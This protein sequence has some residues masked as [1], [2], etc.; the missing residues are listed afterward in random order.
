[1]RSSHSTAYNRM[2][3]SLET[4]GGDILLEVVI[5]LSR[6][7]LLNLVTAVRPPLLL[8]PPVGSR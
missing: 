5:W 6:V 1:M 7:D 2:P 3:M 4:L 8:Q